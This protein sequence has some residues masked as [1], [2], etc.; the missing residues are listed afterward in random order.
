M[1]IIT[2]LKIMGI[3]VWCSKILCLIFYKPCFVFLFI[4]LWDS[5]ICVYM[6]IL[7]VF[8]QGLHCNPSSS[9]VNICIDG[10]AVS[11][12]LWQLSFYL[13]TIGKEEK[14]TF[15]LADTNALHLHHTLKHSKVLRMHNI[16]RILQ[17][18]LM[19]PNLCLS[20]EYWKQGLGMTSR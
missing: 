7:F 19:Q 18:T 13:K 16:C 3:Y 14:A 12:P 11:P 1:L 17:S 10:F 20:K 6:Q 8:L 9:K 4:L 2:W 15:F 5:C